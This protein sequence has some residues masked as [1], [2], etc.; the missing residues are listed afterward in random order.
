VV[1]EDKQGSP[2]AGNRP[3]HTRAFVEKHLQKN[4]NDEVIQ[5][6]PFL[7][8]GEAF[9]LRHY[10]YYPEMYNQKEINLAHHFDNMATLKVYG[11]NQI[12]VGDMVELE[13]L[14]YQTTKGEREID[15]ERSGYYLI[16]EINN[17]FV[18]DN[19]SQEMKISKSGYK[20]KPE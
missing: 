19:Y 3:I 4:A 12:T 14:K 18:E 11:R 15:L 1:P 20:G 2:E 6:Y 9:G 5:D 17:V 8:T 13:I 10:P 16:E 7:S